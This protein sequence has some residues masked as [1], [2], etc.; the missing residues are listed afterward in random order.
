MENGNFGQELNAPPQY[1]SPSYE[2]LKVEVEFQNS[3]DQSVKSTVVTIMPEIPVRD[4]II[5]SFFNSLFLNFCCLGFVAFV[6]SIKSRDRK[7]YGDRNAA[8]SYGSTARSLNIATTVLSILT[9]IIGIIV[10]ATSVH[11]VVQNDR[12][13]HFNFQ[14]NSRGK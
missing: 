1:D 13:R 12:F 14:E 10:F 11:N 9:L 2:P 4:H 7:L 5:W 6:Y 3:A 8:L